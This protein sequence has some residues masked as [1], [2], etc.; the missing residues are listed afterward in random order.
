[1]GLMFLLSGFFSAPSYDR[2]G[3]LHF[4]ADRALRLLLPLLIYDCVI[5]PLAFEIARHS[6]SAPAAL[7]AAHDGFTYYYSTQF[8]R[9]GH[10]VSWYLAVLFIFDLLYVV[11]RVCACGCSHVV[12][13]VG[14]WQ[15]AVACST[16]LQQGATG[17]APTCADLQ[18]DGGCGW[19]GVVHA[20]S[21]RKAAEQLVLP[22]TMPCEPAAAALQE[23]SGGQHQPQPAFSASATAAGLL[24]MGA[25]ISGL[26]LAVRAGILLPLGLQQ[27]MWV[28]QA[29][30]FQPAYL[31]Q[32]FV[33]FLMGLSAFRAGSGLQR[34]PSSVGP[35]AAVVAAVLAVVGGVIMSHFPGSNF[36]VELQREPSLAYV[37]VYTVWEQFYAVTMWLAVLVCFRRWVNKQGGSA[38]TAIA[39]A[40]YAVYLIHV[41]VL[42]AFGLAFAP[43]AWPAAA[44]C[45][46]V[47]PL[48]V[49]SSWL[50][51][52]QLRLLP[53]VK[54]VL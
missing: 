4:L 16:S 38:G 26:C 2:K 54:R 19:T 5:Q 13:A 7:Q 21:G 36:G 35:S 11:A 10:G 20:A 6:P 24:G 25:L 45:L 50:V 14:S 46:V 17:A 8:V 27:S 41:P 53:G 32:Y 43:V 44:K 3:A 51:G 1:M 48:V 9:I 37:A 40:A 34:L 39:G 31:P 22:L 33:A 52:L 15:R 18:H 49:A 12:A 23:T 47:T 28:V 42:T 29:I 30:Q